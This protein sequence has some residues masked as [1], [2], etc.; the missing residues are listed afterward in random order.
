MRG[1]RGGLGGPGG[2]GMMQGSMQEGVAAIEKVMKDNDADANGALSEEEYLAM[3]KK[4]FAESD[5]N[6]D[7]SLD[8]R[9]FIGLIMRMVGRP[10]GPQGMQP[11]VPGGPGAPGA[12]P[13]GA[14]AQEDAGQRGAGGFLARLDSNSD[15][16]ITKDEMPERMQESFAQMDTN[17][18]GALDQT[19][20]S[21]M[22][23][24]LRGRGEGGGAR[25][26][27]PGAG[28]PAQ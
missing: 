13:E 23:E 6:K 3:Q 8:N 1:E 21:A 27:A 12:A 10:G 2:P 7:G 14:A 20:L 11:P 15:G 26:G 4:V 28:T 9:E 19:E 22:G 17:G 16:K 18:D 5:G 25:G 24:R